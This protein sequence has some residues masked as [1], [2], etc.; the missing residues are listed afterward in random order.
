[1]SKGRNGSDEGLGAG[2]CRGLRVRRIVLERH[3]RL[4]GWLRLL[5]PFVDVVRMDLALGEPNEGDPILSRHHAQGGQAARPRAVSRR[6]S[7]L[8]RGS[9]RSRLR[10]GPTLRSVLVARHKEATQVSGP[11]QHLSRDVRTLRPIAEVLRQRFFAAVRPHNS[12]RYRD[13]SHP[14]PPQLCDIKRQTNSIGRGQRPQTVHS[15]VV[16]GTIA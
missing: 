15:V 3:R 8:M 10:S 6:R 16:I 12:C 1:M 4:W 11:S 7:K 5:F 13:M 9:Q 2:R 14:Q